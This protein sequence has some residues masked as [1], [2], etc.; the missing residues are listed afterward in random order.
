MLCC[1]FNT[2]VCAMSL[3][4]DLDAQLRHLM[5]RI[6][7]MV[8]KMGKYGAY[9]VSVLREVDRTDLTSEYS[10]EMDGMINNLSEVVPSFD[11]SYGL[12]ANLTS[13]V[14]DV[15]YFPKRE[16]RDDLSLE[17]YS[18]KLGELSALIKKVNKLDKII[19]FK[20]LK[21]T[22]VNNL[23]NA[24]FQIILPNIKPFVY[25]D[26]NS[27]NIE[28]YITEIEQQ[29]DELAEKLCEF[30]TKFVTN[31]YNEKYAFEFEFGI[32]SVIMHELFE[33][34]SKGRARSGGPNALYERIHTYLKTVPEETL[35]VSAV[36]KFVGEAN[37]INLEKAFDDL[38]AALN[39]IRKA[40]STTE[41]MY[42]DKKN[43]NTEL[44]T[45][46]ITDA[47]DISAE[48]SIQ[49][50]ELKKID[51]QLRPPLKD[52]KRGSDVVDAIKKVDSR[53]SSVKSANNLINE[54]LTEIEKIVYGWTA[55]YPPE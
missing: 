42:N 4:E 15:L 49:V 11:P 43:V 38:W 36:K 21:I 46:F 53:L 10:D 51:L 3:D 41:T 7:Y 28:S 22:E 30:Q 29:I 6:E 18:K 8:S 37:K 19:K 32:V 47:K 13:T 1:T 16:L 14:S 26:L 20:L 17:Q 24:Q 48:I 39:N 34:E 44:I 50:R 45:K 9:C 52:I 23:F 55:R 12:I 33:A 5:Y 31:K 25:E 40:L 2:G 27:Q 54:N 35:E